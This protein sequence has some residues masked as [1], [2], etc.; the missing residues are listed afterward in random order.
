MGDG[1]VEMGDGGVGRSQITFGYT[2]LPRKMTAPAAPSS[3]HC[4]LSLAVNFTVWFGI[5]DKLPFVRHY[6]MRQ[7]LT[8]NGSAGIVI[9]MLHN[10]L[11]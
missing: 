8:F 4:L 2:T 3:S 7:D 10:C 11:C 5:V 1:G 6:Q 9:A